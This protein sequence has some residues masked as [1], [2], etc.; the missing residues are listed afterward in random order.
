MEIVR[1]P[2]DQTRDQSLQRVRALR[3]SLR[4]S[5]QKACIE[6]VRSNKLATRTFNTTFEFDGR[7]QD[8]RRSIAKT[9]ALFHRAI[10][11]QFPYLGSAEH[12]FLHSRDRETV[13]ITLKSERENLPE[14]PNALVREDRH[15]TARNSFWGRSL[16]RYLRLI[17]FLC[18]KHA[19]PFRIDPDFDI[20]YFTPPN[21]PYSFRYSL[22]LNISFVY[23]RELRFTPHGSFQTIA[24]FL[25]NRLE[26][27]ETETQI[28][29]SEHWLGAHIGGG[30]PSDI[31]SMGPYQTVE[32]LF[33]HVP[34]ILKFLGTLTRKT[35]Y[36]PS[37]ASIGTPESAGA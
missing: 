31:G 14:Y 13:V 29:D 19:L 30:R 12:Q 6:Q 10:E 17:Q 35:S 24:D 33:F 28:F 20:D 2:V 26:E 4:D 23:W 5:I 7:R 21:R 25:A 3:S 32:R 22:T 1:I 18:L 34:Q 11:K 9:K 16:R 36:V 27:G 15:E 37:A 8:I